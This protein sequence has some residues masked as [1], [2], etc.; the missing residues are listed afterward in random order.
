MSKCGVCCQGE[1]A[2]EIAQVEGLHSTEPRAAGLPGPARPAPRDATSR[3]P[4]RLVGTGEPLL[5]AKALQLLLWPEWYCTA[6]L[7]AVH[8]PQQPHLPYFPAGTAAWR[9]LGAGARQQGGLQKAVQA[10]TPFAAD[11]GLLAPR[12]T[13]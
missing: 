7:P 13:A 2:K 12:C 1:Q 11:V 8:Y 3:A 4:L 10:W 5:D 9:G 6:V